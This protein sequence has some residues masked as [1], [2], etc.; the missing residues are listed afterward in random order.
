MQEDTK[1]QDKWI[2]EM[3]R[4]SSLSQNAMK[5]T[6]IDLPITI[7]YV[8]LENQLE[9]KKQDSITLHFPFD[10]SGNLH[11][12]T[13]ATKEVLLK[14][15]CDYKK[16][17]KQNSRFVCKELLLYHLPIEPEQVQQLAQCTNLNSYTQRY[18]KSFP[19]TDSIEIEPSIFIFHQVNQLY[20]LF[21]EV[22]SLK[23]CLKTNSKDE[24][25]RKQSTAKMCKSTKRVRLKIARHTRRN[26]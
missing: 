13:F 5:E 21:R 11:Q 16:N 6:C 1:A 23:S 2:Q 14:K 7:L 12:K 8:N 25:D 24:N 20:F 10:T 3:E 26:F 4:I 17:G 9:E 18:F 15:M 19:V 22:P